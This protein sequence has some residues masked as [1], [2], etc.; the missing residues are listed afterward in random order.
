L[1][2]AQVEEKGEGLEEDEEVQS[3][4]MSKDVWG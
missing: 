4:E 2:E 3:K 1:E